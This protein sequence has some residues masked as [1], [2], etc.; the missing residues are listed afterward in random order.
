MIRVL[1]TLV[2]LLG[3]F[4]LAQADFQ[5]TKTPLS[6]DGHRAV[7]DLP[8]SLHM[9]NVGGSDGAGLCVYTSVTHAARWQNL[10][11]M[12]GFRKWAERRPGGS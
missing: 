1:S 3:T 7:I 4:G 10:P 9:K 8:S 6:P 5:P 12:D 11:Q 2:L